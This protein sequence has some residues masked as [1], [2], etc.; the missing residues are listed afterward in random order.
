V[1]RGG[2][3]FDDLA[4]I[5][6]ATRGGPVRGRRFA[7][8]LAPLLE[9]EAR[10]LEIGVGTGVV[11]LGLRGLGFPVVGVDLSPRML[12]HA[13][14]RLGARVAVGD[15][16]A[17]P[18]RDGSVRQAYSVWVLH[19]VTSVSDVLSELARVIVP[20][21]RYV[22]VD[23]AVPPANPDAIWRITR[24]LRRAVEPPERRTS[25]DLDA[26][27][28]AADAVGLRFFDIF[29]SSEAEF[30][31]SP[32]EAARDIEAR[33]FSYLDEVDDGRWAEFVVPALQALR[34]LPDP[35]RP[36]RRIASPH[37]MVVFDRD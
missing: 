18:V 15:A 22:V 5:Y 1:S 14:E 30:F 2:R 32:E 31:Q 28:A 25:E 33:S 34:A 24:D 27:R 37:R 7:I 6:D 3:S 23:G 29:L 8:D 26:L 11:A 36:I 19:L 16:A 9:P 13:R 12:A 10:T 20:G 21:G 4:D 17:L 35:E